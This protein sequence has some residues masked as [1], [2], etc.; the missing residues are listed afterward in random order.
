MEASNTRNKQTDRFQPFA[1]K[2]RVQ[3]RDERTMNKRNATQDKGQRDIYIFH[4]SD[5]RTNAKEDQ[6]HQV[7]MSI[8]SK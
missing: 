3:D 7:R 5:E 4:T 8:A 1:Y 6:T 2:R